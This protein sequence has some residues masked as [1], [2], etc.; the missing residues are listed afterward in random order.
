[1]TK[2]PKAILGKFAEERNCCD[3]L[4]IIE[5][6]IFF[7]LLM[8]MGTIRPWCQMLGK[9]PRLTTMLNNLGHFPNI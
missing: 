7:R 4:L 9:G 8:L 3:L 6:N 1:M 5:Q 2:F